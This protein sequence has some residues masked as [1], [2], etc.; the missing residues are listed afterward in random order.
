VSLVD[1]AL[2]YAGLSGIVDA[3]SQSFTDNSYAG[4]TDALVDYL[5]AIAGLE[6][7]CGAFAG[8][9]VGEIPSLGADTFATIL[10]GAACYEAVKNLVAKSEAL[11]NCISSVNAQTS[12]ALA[13]AA[14]TI[15]ANL[16][17]VAQQAVAM[18]E[19]QGD[20]ATV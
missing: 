10:A 7:G 17:T 1:D 19:Q 8:L 11:A 16:E 13:S 2:N 12:A 5:T 14:Q 18:Q 6:A 15:D 9:L 3:S 4:C 20:T